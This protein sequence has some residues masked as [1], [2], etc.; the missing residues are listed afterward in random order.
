M[1]YNGWVYEK[2]FYLEIPKFIPTFVKKLSYT[3]CYMNVKLN[4]YGTIKK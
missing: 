3:T 1:S 4:G 2:V